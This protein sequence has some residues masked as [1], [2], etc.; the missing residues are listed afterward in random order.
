MKNLT[1]KEFLNETLREIES[2]STSLKKKEEKLKDEMEKW[3]HAV[4]TEPY[5]LPYESAEVGSQYIHGGLYDAREKLYSEFEGTVPKH[6]IEELANKLEDKCSEWSKIPDP[7]GA[8]Q[9]RI[10]QLTRLL[11]ESEQSHNKQIEEKELEIARLQ[12]QIRALKV[13]VSLK[14]E[15]GIDYTKLRDLLAA[16]KWFEADQETGLLMCQAAGRESEGWLRSF[17]L[18]NFPCE[19]LRTINQLWLQ[20]SDGKFGFSIQKKIYESLAGTRE[21]NKSG[22]VWKKFGV[23]VGWRK[24]GFWLHYD[25]LTFN[26]SAPTAHL[27][28]VLWYGE[29]GMEVFIRGGIGCSSSL[30]QRL[31]TC[32]L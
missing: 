19:D 7:D 21:D 10:E 29:S 13:E 3:F 9:K 11:E 5:D 16:G 20:H 6:L 1:R 22:S 30:V 23:L 2:L 12:E 14:S 26:K 25:D 15:K 24:G 27:P 32:K 17:E 28:S 18:D 8:Q 4:F 31:V